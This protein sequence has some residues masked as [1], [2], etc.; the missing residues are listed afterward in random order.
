MKEKLNKNSLYGEV[1]NVNKEE[2]RPI[3][4]VI[5]G[6]SGT[7][8]DTVLRN[9]VENTNIRQ[10]IRYTDRPK[11]PGEVHGREYYFLSK[12]EMQEKIDKN[13]FTVLES[14][15]TVDGI[16]RYGTDLHSVIDSKYSH[17][18]TVSLH[19][20][21]DLMKWILSNDVPYRWL[22]L[23][24]EDGN[25]AIRLFSR[26]LTKDPLEFDEFARRWNSDI[27]DNIKFFTDMESLLGPDAALWES[28][29][30]ISNDGSLSET[31]KDIYQIFI[32]KGD[33]IPEGSSKKEPVTF[34]TS[35]GSAIIPEALLQKVRKTK[36]VSTNDTKPRIES[37]DQMLSYVERVYWHDRVLLEYAQEVKQDLSKWCDIVIN[38]EP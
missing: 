18:M 24:M 11:R 7:G 9:I 25:R 10:I 33:L 5:S 29:Y 12:E 30:S 8:K 14:F 21:V 32:Q 17:I 4:Y 16:W 3:L 19:D 1:C 13:E 34:Q 20:S 22:Y 38:E 28:F 15:N 23:H 36:P 31:L 35:T 27:Q 2:R 6:K 26:E 37:V